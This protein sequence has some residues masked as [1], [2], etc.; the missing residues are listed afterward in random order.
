MLTN[1]PSDHVNMRERTV[2]V[3]GVNLLLTVNMVYVSS[4]LFSYKKS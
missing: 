3:A 1:E 4:I 2:K